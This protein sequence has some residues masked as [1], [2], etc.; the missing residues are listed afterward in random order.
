MFLDSNDETLFDDNNVPNSDSDPNNEIRT[1]HYSMV[2]IV[3]IL[4]ILITIV[5]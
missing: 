4:I 5:V 3:A 1:T 2:I